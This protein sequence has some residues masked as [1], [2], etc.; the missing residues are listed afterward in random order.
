MQDNISLTPDELSEN[1]ISET[2]NEEGSNNSVDKTSR[3]EEKALMDRL[4]EV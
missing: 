2:D 1:D 3:H 4:R